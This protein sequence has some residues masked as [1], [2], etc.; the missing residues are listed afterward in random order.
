MK[1]SYIPILNCVFAGLT[2]ARYMYTEFKDNSDKTNYQ[3]NANAI[4]TMHK[5]VAEFNDVI[6]QDA[7]LSILFTDWQDH[8]FFKE[9]PFTDAMNFVI[10]ALHMRNSAYQNISTVGAAESMKVSKIGSLRYMKAERLAIPL[11]KL[12]GV[13]QCEIKPLEFEP[14][15]MDDMG[16]YQRFYMCTNKRCGNEESF[17][18]MGSEKMYSNLC[19][20]IQPWG[21]IN[22]EVVAEHTHINSQKQKNRN[23]K[24]L[25]SCMINTQLPYK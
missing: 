23:S 19:F 16:S 14:L 5:K 15:Y 24:N 12:L 18:E 7:E 17:Q 8:L 4:H 20:K 10:T 11:V 22:S 1:R 6:S 2:T 25:G 9:L 21:I 3:A 13:I